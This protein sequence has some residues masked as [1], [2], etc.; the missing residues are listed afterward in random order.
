[1]KSQAERLTQIVALL[2]PDGSRRLPESLTAAVIAGDLAHI[3]QFVAN[4]ASIEERSM[5]HANPLAAACTS[6]QVEAARWLIARG[7]VLDPPGA[8][9]SPIQAALGK[10]N[11]EVAALLLDAG[12]PV[13][14]AAWGAVAAASLG[15]LDVLHWLV[16][17]G[18]DLDGSYPGVGVLRESALRSAKKDGGE[19]LRRYLRGELELGPP[20]STPPAASSGTKTRPNVSEA[21]RESLLREA[22]ELVGA[23]GKAAG[24]W[25]ASG[26]S[27]PPQRQI[28]IS[29]AAG[30]GCTAIVGALLDVGASPND[31]P[32]GTPP[33][34]T[35]AAANGE[36]DVAR[37]LLDRGARPDGSDGK[38]WLPLV[39]AAQSGS[40]D[41]VRLLL[42]AGAN[43]KAKPPGGG[44]LVDHARGPYA[45][46]IRSMLE[47]AA[48]A[49]KPR[50]SRTTR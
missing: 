45:G 41:M 16:G 17:R 28:L 6:G 36:V 35:E 15:R 47:A 42:E 23:A 30:A 43:A 37:L 22:L 33:P 4:G 1:M 40:P 25:S 26:A 10:G 44:K 49:A 12:L 5:G 14:R 19:D 7:A 27:A 20:P 21:E 29:F 18:L 31:A 38:S 48:G 32:E 8:P 3:E 2:R 34:L 46:E 9:I 50:R 24:H 39:A 13:E 11:C